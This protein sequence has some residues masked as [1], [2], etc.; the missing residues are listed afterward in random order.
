M[1]II[2][3]DKSTVNYIIEYSIYNNI[4]LQEEYKVRYIMNKNLKIKEIHC[5]VCLFH[6]VVCSTNGA[7]SYIHCA[8]TL[9]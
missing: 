7:T 4:G 9:N 2:L 8:K 3:L 1:F 6:R 5:V